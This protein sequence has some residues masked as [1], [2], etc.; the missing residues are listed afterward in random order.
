[1]SVT[2]ITETDKKTVTDALS[3][4][5]RITGSTS[6]YD[7]DG[8]KAT[9]DDYFTSVDDIPS[10]YRTFTNYAYRI[11]SNLD[12]PENIAKRV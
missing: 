3:S 12:T 10:G 11:M 7:V 1:M 4:V 5:T 6:S 8:L 2:D 9:A